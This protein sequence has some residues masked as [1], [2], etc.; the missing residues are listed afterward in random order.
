VGD[1]LTA[2]FVAAEHSSAKK[3][4]ISELALKEQS[5]LCNYN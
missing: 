5:K 3:I 4:V 1:L 2:K